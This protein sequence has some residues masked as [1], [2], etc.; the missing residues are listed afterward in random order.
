MKTIALFGLKGGVGRTTL[1]YHL[2]WMM[3]ERGLRVLTVD[4]DPQ[5][6]L[7]MLS[8]GADRAAAL[9]GRRDAPVSVFS[10]LAPLFFEGKP[11]AV[12]AATVQSLS[13]RLALLPGDLELFL[14]LGPLLQSWQDASSSGDAAAVQRTAAFSH[15]I[16]GHGD[17]FRANVALIDLG[18]NLNAIN[19]A[20]LVAADHVV[21][22][23]VPDQISVQSLELI[24]QA[25]NEWRNGWRV[26][27]SRS[28]DRPPIPALPLGDMEPIGYLLSRLSMSKGFLIHADAQSVAAIPAAYA[29]S[30][31]GEPTPPPSDDPNCL[32]H[33]KD[34]RSLVTM[35][36]EARKPM[37]LL[38]PGDGAIGGHQGAVRDCYADFRAL[39]N[40]IASR[41]GV[42]LPNP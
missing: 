8:L 19:R 1:V 38:K 35:A 41:I 14:F 25:L 18:P 27:A 31:V 39:A 6:N 40:R 36:Q 26:I 13:E 23:L 10:A 3:A 30:V 15:L 32:A 37:F 22:P 28:F 33:V 11:V 24:G 21:V 5:A 20:A 16:R 4:L 42:P 9:L 29:R 7:T 17:A 34:Y 2:A 12:A